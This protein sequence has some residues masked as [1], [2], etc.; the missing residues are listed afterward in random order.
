ML[1]STVDL[2]E[3]DGPED[4]DVLALLDVEVDVEQ[5]LVRAERL[6]DAA[7]LDDGGSHVFILRL[8]P[9]SR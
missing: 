9:R 2:P 7:Q 8:A 3:P 1:R 6:V 4:D 5:H